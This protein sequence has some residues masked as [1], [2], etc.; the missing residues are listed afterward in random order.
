MADDSSD[1]LTYYLQVDRSRIQDLESLRDWAYVE[2]AVGN[3]TIWVTGLSRRLIES[4]AIQSLP[5]KQLYSCK[6]GWLYPL[7]HLLPER[8]QPVLN[9]QP[10]SHILEITMPVF[11]HNYFG[12]EQHIEINL[13]PSEISR[14]ATMMHTSVEAAREY[15]ES[16]PEVR[17]RNISWLWLNE[18]D[19]LLSGVPLL[20]LPGE[21]FWRNQ[22]HLIPSGYQFE[23]PVLS[24]ALSKRLD[25]SQQDWLI[26]QKDSSYVRVAKSAFIPLTIS[27]FR[28]TLEQHLGA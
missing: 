11:N 26:W 7:H 17:L 8:E 28:K 14:K 18:Q 10:I 5:F 19:L 21:V 2:A 15:I 1:D 25:P 16:A 13:I 20:P 9:W 23:L 24:E 3:D 12:V 6:G 4:V 22:N 27:S